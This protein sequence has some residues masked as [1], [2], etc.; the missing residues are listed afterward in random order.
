MRRFTLTTLRDFGMGKKSIEEKII[1]EAGFLV[2]LFKSYNGQPIQPQ[3]ALD[4][5]TANIIAVLLFQQRFDYEDESLRRFLTTS[6]QMQKDKS[7]RMVRITNA[8]PFLKFLPGAHKRVMD[9][10]K[11]V[12]A[13]LITIIAK[14]RKQLNENDVGNLIE[15]FLVKQKE[16]PCLIRSSIGNSTV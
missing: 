10:T 2:N 12:T 9:Q 13:F 5:A 6:H 15:A 8:L 7:S 16:V 1:E 3:N 4:T 11:E 14:I